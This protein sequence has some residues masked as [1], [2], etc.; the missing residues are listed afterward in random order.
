VLEKAN[1]VYHA[2]GD[3]VRYVE[4]QHTAGNISSMDLNGLI[5][6]FR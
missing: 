1:Q 5:S 6:I 3:P 4:D 2:G